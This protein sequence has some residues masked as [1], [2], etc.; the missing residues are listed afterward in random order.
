MSLL[1]T[2]LYTTEEGA[3]I[4]AIRERNPFQREMSDEEKLLWKALMASR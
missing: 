2:K 3:C 1:I 4:R